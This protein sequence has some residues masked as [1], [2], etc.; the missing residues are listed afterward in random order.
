VLPNQEKWSRTNFYFNGIH[1]L[2][3]FLER[4]RL[5]TSISTEQMLQR[6]AL[7]GHLDVSEL[8]CA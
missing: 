6:L 3:L 2:R 8:M 1:E 5:P 7:A 4:W